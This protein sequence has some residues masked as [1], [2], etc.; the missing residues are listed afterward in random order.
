MP[1]VE[2]STSRR[3]MNDDLDDGNQ[4]G[5]RTQRGGPGIKVPEI[6]LED[7]TKSKHFLKY[8]S[9]VKPRPETNKGT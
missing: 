2:I 9:M 6:T 4:R 8:G 3:L 7:T 1:V 5:G